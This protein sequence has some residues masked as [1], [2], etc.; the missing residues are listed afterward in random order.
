MNM[1]IQSIKVYYITIFFGV[2][3]GF[4]KTHLIHNLNFLLFLSFFLNLLF[5]MSFSNQTHSLF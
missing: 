2:F 5:K 3:Y 1:K 4:L